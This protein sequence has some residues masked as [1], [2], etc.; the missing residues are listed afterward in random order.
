VALILAFIIVP[1]SVV[2]FVASAIST[3]IRADIATGTIW[4]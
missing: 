3:A 4:Q 1:F 2:S